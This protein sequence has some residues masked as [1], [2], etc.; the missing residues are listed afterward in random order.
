MADKR[1]IMAAHMMNGVDGGMTEQE[2]L[3]CL[4]KIPV[5][6]LNDFVYTLQLISEKNVFDCGIRI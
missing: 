2:F 6:K 4:A 1:K 3:T 5:D